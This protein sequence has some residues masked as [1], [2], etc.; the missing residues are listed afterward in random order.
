MGT[1]RAGIKGASNSD[2]EIIDSYLVIL[3]HVL[4]CTYSKKESVNVSR[5][6][7]MCK[8]HNVSRR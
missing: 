1:K 7:I 3:E 8:A 2:K 5:L 4:P 6:P